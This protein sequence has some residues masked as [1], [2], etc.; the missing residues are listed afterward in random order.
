MPDPNSSV[1]I[2]VYSRP[3]CHLCD[4]A[5]DVIE[6]VRAK[7]N[8]VLSVINIDQDPALAAEYGTDIPVVVINS[9]KA[10][11]YRVDEAEFERKV[12][13]LWKT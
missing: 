5:M 3:G 6:R 8:F 10:F 13:R 1:R 7:Y 9:N 11:K 12:K 2:D 4:E